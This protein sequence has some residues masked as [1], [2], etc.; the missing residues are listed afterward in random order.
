MHTLFTLIMEP[1]NIK[2]FLVFF[3]LIEKT[4]YFL[5]GM[6]LCDAKYG[7]YDLK[8][9]LVLKYLLVCF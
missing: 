6:I 9:D 2:F 5:F 4:K 8:C 7:H 3:F 1:K